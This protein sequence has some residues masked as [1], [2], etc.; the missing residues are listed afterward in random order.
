MSARQPDTLAAQLERW[1]AADLLSNEQA[2]AILDFEALSVKHGRTKF[3]AALIISIIG[4]LTLGLG[5][6]ALV[7]ANWGTLPQSLKFGG[8]VLLTLSSYAAG[9][10]LRDRPEASWPGT[11]AALYLLGG[12]LFGAVLAFLSQGMQLNV[13]V[14]TLLMLW[15][16]GLL[17]LA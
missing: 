4:A 3:S 16:A 12:V 6:I 14:S 15:G 2:Q 8:L 10:L 17:A 13:N 5:I 11:G 7:A 9:Y 1:R